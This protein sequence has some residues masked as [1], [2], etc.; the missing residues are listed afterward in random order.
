[1]LYPKGAPRDVS[2]ARYAGPES[3]FCP[4][5]VYEYPEPGKL[6]I[7]AA[8]CIHCKTCD[9]KTPANYVQWTVPEAGGGGPSYDVL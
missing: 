9:I 5:R 7:N 2:F 8:N 3:R 1:M 6:V 4:A